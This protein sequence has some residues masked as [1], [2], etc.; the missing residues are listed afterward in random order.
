MILTTIVFGAS[1]F[2]VGYLPLYKILMKKFF[3]LKF[4]I[5][6]NFSAEI[7]VLFI[8]IKIPIG[9]DLT[10]MEKLNFIQ[11]NYRLK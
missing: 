4:I 8:R 9:S 6:Y 1:H 10:P 11:E 3:Y 7:R 2:Q 5:M